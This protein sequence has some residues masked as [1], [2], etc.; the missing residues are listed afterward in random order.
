[1]KIKHSSITFIL[2]FLLTTV[3]FS[4][5][6]SSDIKKS[7]F[8]FTGTATNKEAKSKSY[9]KS[10]PD[11]PSIKYVVVEGAQALS[12]SYNSLEKYNLNFTGSNSTADNV[13]KRRVSKSIS[14][15]II[16]THFNKTLPDQLKLKITTSGRVVLK[17]NA[18]AKIDLKLQVG[19]RT[20]GFKQENVRYVF[21][22]DEGDPGNINVF[23]KHNVPVSTIPNGGYF[24]FTYQDSSYKTIIGVKEAVFTTNT[25]TE[26]R[27]LPTSESYSYLSTDSEFDLIK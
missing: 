3:C 11:S 17:G 16:N 13:L 7:T 21:R 26:T 25:I 4:Q 15:D 10:S 2:F 24:W 14:R 27:P 20:L 9:N 23:D 12:K 22:L 6:E 19:N 8:L 1:M 18:T 5:I